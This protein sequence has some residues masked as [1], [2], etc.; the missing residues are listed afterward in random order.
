LARVSKRKTPIAEE[1]HF[2]PTADLNFV[3]AQ[4]R[5]ERWRA[6]PP[7]PRVTWCSGLTPR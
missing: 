7:T 6:S 3:K 2:K 4:I 5:A 1:A